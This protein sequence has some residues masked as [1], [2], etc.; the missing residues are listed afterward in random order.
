M[1][2]T[3]T[4]GWL[5]RMSLDSEIGAGDYTVSLDCDQSQGTMNPNGPRQLAFDWLA[6]AGAMDGGHRT[7]AFPVFIRPIRL[8]ATPYRFA[9]SLCV[10][11]DS[12]IT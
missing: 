9:K 2:F 12:R 1:R 11:E 8:C 4:L 3:D 6:T 5:L 7:H 10:S